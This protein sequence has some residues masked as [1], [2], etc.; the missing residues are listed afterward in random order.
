MIKEK[1]EGENILLTILNVV[2]A[3]L[4]VSIFVD[5]IKHYRKNK[6]K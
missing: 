2:V 3:I 5:A 1:G 6:K 4:A